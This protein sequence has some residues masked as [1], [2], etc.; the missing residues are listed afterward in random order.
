[1]YCFGNLEARELVSDSIWSPAPQTNAHFLMRNMPGCP[2]CIQPKS[3]GCMRQSTGGWRRTAEF[4][5][6]IRNVTS[7]NT[8]A[9]VSAENIAPLC[10][11]WWGQCSIVHEITDDNSQLVRKN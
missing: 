10:H 7:L 9:A 8:S 2:E 6:D 1:M 4:H 5:M 11:N 3:H